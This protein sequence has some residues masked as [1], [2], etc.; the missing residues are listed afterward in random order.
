MS[1]LLRDNVQT[2]IFALV[3]ALPE[4]VR[5]PAMSATLIVRRIQT[6]LNFRVAAVP[7][8]KPD[9]VKPASDVA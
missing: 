8:F 7:V 5:R 1:A 3:M 9:L 2:T 4:P 6:V